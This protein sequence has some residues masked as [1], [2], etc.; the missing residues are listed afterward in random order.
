[1]SC[2]R[3]FSFDASRTFGQRP[4]STHA[5]IISILSRKVATV[6]HALLLA[7]PAG[8][9]RHFF[10]DVARSLRSHQHLRYMVA[11]MR[12]LGGV[13]E[14]ECPICGTE[15]LFHAH[16]HPPRYDAVCP[17]CGS[18]ERH[19]LFALLLRVRP[20]LGVGAR[21]IHFA[22]EPLLAPEL[23]RRA[24]DYRSSDPIRPG[25]D[26]KLDIEALDLPDAVVDLFV[27]NHVLEHVD[28]RKALAE[29]HRCLRP[30]GIAV[31]TTPVVEGWRESYEDPAIASGSSDALR[32]L[33]F[34]QADHVRWFGSDLRGRICAARFELEEFTPRGGDAVRYGLTRGET[35]FI[36][37]KPNRVRSDQ[38]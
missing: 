26:L 25:C 30:G 8:V 33:H 18:I 4:P 21:T 31:I 13:V 16:G 38:P 36:A 34:G 17:H 1:M 29:L 12:K 20:E 23:R 32:T 14:R 37:R 7:R 3:I 9:K 35:V 11:V 27:L 19:R 5:D 15:G 6:D 24:T 2:R 22:P 10:R 28:D